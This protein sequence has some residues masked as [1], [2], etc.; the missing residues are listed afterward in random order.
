ME[1]SDLDS[2]EAD[3]VCSPLAVGPLSKVPNYCISLKASSS[4][5]HA[6]VV[7]ESASVSSEGVV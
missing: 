7:F 6:T 3:D 4:F 1:V 5:Y 2:C